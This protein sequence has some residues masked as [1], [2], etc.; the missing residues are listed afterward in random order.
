MKSG[1]GYVALIAGIFVC[2]SA[3]QA[4]NVTSRSPFMPE[5]GAAPGAV[6][7]ENNPLELRGIVATKNGYLYGIFDP[8]KRQSYWVRAN[9]SGAEFVVRGHD[10]QNETVS[11]DFQGRSM[12]LALKAAKVES[13]GPVPNPAIANVQNPAAVSRVPPNMPPVALNPTPADEARRLESVAAEVRRRRMLRQAASQQGAQ[14]T[15]VQPVPMPPQGTPA[16]QPN[17]AP[18]P[19]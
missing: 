16:P 3:L 19:R 11:V 12:T 17:P 2:G 18:Q 5:G 9:E 6:P 8:T 4:Q 1:I 13:L 14:P 15:T 7:T 10:I